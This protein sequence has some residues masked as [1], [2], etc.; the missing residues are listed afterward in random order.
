[1]EIC[2]LSP[3]RDPLGAAGVSLAAA[4]QAMR[5]AAQLVGLADPDGWA[6]PAASFYQVWAEDV[7]HRCVVAAATA[8]ASA[9]RMAEFQTLLPTV[10]TVP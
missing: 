6:S 3:L 10:R 4:G 1:M 8:E 5:E 9:D 2:Y 7:R